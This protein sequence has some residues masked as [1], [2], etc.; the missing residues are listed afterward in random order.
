VLVLTEHLDRVGSAVVELASA[1]ESRFAQVLSI[2]ELQSGAQ[3]RRR[4][5]HR[6][7]SGV[8]AQGSAEAESRSFASRTTSKFGSR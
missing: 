6:E 4:R 7:A 1:G 2:G 8:V 3:M 5:E